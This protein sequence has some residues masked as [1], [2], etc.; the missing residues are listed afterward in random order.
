V[1]PLAGDLRA[2]GMSFDAIATEPTGHYIL[3]AHCGAW[4][5]TTLRRVKA[6]QLP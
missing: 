5:A 3:T 6:K 1:A 4:I 2:Q